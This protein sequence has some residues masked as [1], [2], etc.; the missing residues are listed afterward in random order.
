MRFPDNKLPSAETRLTAIR[1]GVAEIPDYRSVDANFSLTHLLMLTPCSAAS[2][3]SRR[4]SAGDIRNAK[5]PLNF[6]SASGSGTYRW[7]TR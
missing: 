1:A 7:P 6:R 2:I 4:C 3:A 5:C